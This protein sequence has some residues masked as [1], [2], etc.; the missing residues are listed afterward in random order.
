MPSLNM[1]SSYSFALEKID[2]VV[3]RRSPG[4]YA[5]GYVLENSFYVQYVGRSDIDL[6]Q[7]LK[8][9]HSQFSQKEYKQFKYSYASSV[10]EAFEKECTNYHDFVGDSLHN[11]RHP[12]RPNQM[13]WKCPRCDTFG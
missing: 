6:N 2:E 13:H 5:L 7:E 3:T 4:N 9:R 8:A 1:S 11:E 10:K 12:D